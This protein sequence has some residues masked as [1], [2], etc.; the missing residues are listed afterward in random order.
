MSNGTIVFLAAASGSFLVLGALPMGWLADR[1][2]RGPI[3]GWATLA[4]A[5]FLALVWCGHQCVPAV[6]D[7][8]RRR[9]R[10]VEHLP[11]AR[12]AARRHVS[13]HGSRPYQRDAGHG[14]GFVGVLS[15]LLVG[16]IAA[17][18]GG[19][20]GWRWPSCSSAFPVAIV[21]F[22][23]FRLKEPPRGQFEKQDVLGEVI[24]D[25]KPAPI[26][27]E[28]AFARLWQ[29][30]TLKTVILAFAAMGFGLFTMPV[31]A[32]LFIED[33]YGPGTFDRGVVGTS[34]ASAY[35]S[36]C[37]SSVGT[38]TGST[39][40]PGAR[41]AARR[42]ADPAGRGAHAGAVL[43]AQRGR[44]SRSG[45]PAADH[46]VDRVHDGRRSCSRSCRTGCAAWARR[47]GRSTSSSSA[48]PAARCSPRLLTD[49]FGSRTA[50]LVIVVPSTHHR[51]VP[52]PSRRARSSATTCRWS[53]GSSS[54][55]M[56]EHKRQ[57][58]DARRRSP[59]CRSSTSTS[60]TGRCRCSS[61]SA[62]RCGAARCSRCSARTARA[63]RRSCASSPGSGR[64]RAVSCA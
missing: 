47:S 32:N 6:L 60:P 20:D 38:T 1:L 53:S 27:I 42:V 57:Q 31:L 41:V 44:C 62:S 9:C 18:A 2:R 34:A 39:A 63:S 64:R 49:A 55:E 33:E 11:G 24:E 21:A 17:A 15:P 40:R 23:A 51:R 36:C 19:A 58:A 7:A 26:S 35:C 52:D 28:A 30:R 14:A 22:F 29:I 13:D 12:F 16:G 45:H 25:A 50:V 10:E 37:R 59:R 3:I 43:H 46:A 5:G 61:T 48:R 56:D 54:E 4:F 8:A